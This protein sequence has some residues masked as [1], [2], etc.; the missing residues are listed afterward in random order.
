MTEEPIV[1]RWDFDKMT[2]DELLY[3]LGYSL[4][5]Y[6]KIKQYLDSAIV[7]DKPTK[8]ENA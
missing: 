3:D 8:K 2:E 1:H 4:F 6:N 5:R 7:V